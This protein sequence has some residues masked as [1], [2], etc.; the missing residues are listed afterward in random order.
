MF[1]ISNSSYP[2]YVLK[3]GFLHSPSFW[4]NDLNFKNGWRKPWG[5]VDV[6]AVWPI[7]FVATVLLDTVKDIKTSCPSTAGP[8][9][10]SQVPTT[11]EKLVHLVRLLDGTRL[12]M[13]MDG[14]QL[15]RREHVHARLYAM[16]FQFVLH[17]LYW[18]QK[19][20]NLSI[21]SDHVIWLQ[22]EIHYISHD[23]LSFGQVRVRVHVIIKMQRANSSA[24]SLINSIFSN[25]SYTSSLTMVEYWIFGLA[26]KKC[27][28]QTYI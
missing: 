19:T 2:N 4:K 10:P 22:Q 13:E 14:I 20:E 8:H 7:W 18:I 6:H 12:K 3:L 23:P 17:Q 5:T 16:I 21:K 24:Y 28:S 27:S 11:C 26:R 1:W 25:P 15:D 9:A